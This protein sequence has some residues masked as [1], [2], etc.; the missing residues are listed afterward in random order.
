LPGPEAIFFLR[1]KSVEDLVAGRME[2]AEAMREAVEGAARYDEQ[3]G[4]NPPWVRGDAVR[5]APDGALRGLPGSPGSAE[6]P[7]HRVFSARDFPNFPPGA[8]L[9]ARTTNPAWTPLFYGAAAVVTES[10]GPLSHGAVTARE[11]GI[12]AVMAVHGALEALPD[13]TR[14]RVNGT[15]GFVERL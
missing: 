5:A 8:V 13:G 9:V 1:R 15:S 4:T 3:A 10:G 14:V 2:A 12:P 11:V 7:V 6:G